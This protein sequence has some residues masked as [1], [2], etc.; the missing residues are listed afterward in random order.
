[1]GKLLL[2]PKGKLLI[3]VNAVANPCKAQAETL[4][5]IS[6]HLAALSLR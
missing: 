6:K 2:I 1:M 4:A 3:V 5:S